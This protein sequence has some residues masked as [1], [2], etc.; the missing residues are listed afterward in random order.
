MLHAFTRIPNSVSPIITLI[1][2]SLIKFSSI[3]SLF[4]R[5]IDTA[6]L[7]SICKIKKSRRPSSALWVWLVR[8]ELESRPSCLISTQKRSEWKR[9]NMVRHPKVSGLRDIVSRDFDFLQ[10]TRARDTICRLT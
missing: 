10:V 4:Q 2:S 9:S 7:F 5:E 6:N 3:D 8:F 1:T